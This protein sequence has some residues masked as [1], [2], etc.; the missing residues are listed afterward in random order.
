MRIQ[1]Q[2]SMMNGYGLVFSRRSESNNHFACCYHGCEKMYQDPKTLNSHVHP[3]RGD[4]AHMIQEQDLT[5]PRPEHKHYWAWLS[6]LREMTDVV[7]MAKNFEASCHQQGHRHKFVIMETPLPSIGFKMAARCFVLAM[8]DAT[9][10]LDASEENGQF[11]V[12]DTRLLP[13][14]LVGQA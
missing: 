1:H 7:Q 5:I 8:Y 14:N 10:G 4:M 11:V 6:Q 2:S 12:L 13:R 3:T 9:I